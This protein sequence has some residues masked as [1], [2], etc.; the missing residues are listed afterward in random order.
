MG[1]LS[2]THCV[3]VLASLHLLAQRVHPPPASLKLAQDGYRAHSYDKDADLEDPV[4]QREFSLVA[5][6]ERLLQHIANDPDMETDDFAC[7]FEDDI[8]LHDELSHKAARRAVLHGMDLAR[9]DGLLNLGIC[10]P[11]CQNASSRWWEGNLY[12]KCASL[13]THA[14]A[15]TKGKASTLMSEV[16]EAIHADFKA[17]GYQSYYHGHA[18]DQ[19][20]RLYA[21]HNNGT[22]AAAT[23]LR[24]DQS[25]AWGD[26]L[27]V[28]YQDRWRTKSTINARRAA[29]RALLTAGVRCA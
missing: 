27:G 6:W 28:F 24:S 22:W 9:A 1:C 2:L 21:W 14:L 4:T 23:N 16:H 7:I 13:C 29:R 18:I 15:V 19:L 25:P 20:L 11:D 17:W 5:A 10:R 8:A 3:Q 12:Q 26:E